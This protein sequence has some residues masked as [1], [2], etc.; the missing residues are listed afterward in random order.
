MK[1]VNRWIVNITMS[2]KR[3]W[4]I[5]ND[6]LKNELAFLYLSRFLSLQDKNVIVLWVHA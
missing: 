4:T 3:Q 1:R 6:T 5:N 2:R